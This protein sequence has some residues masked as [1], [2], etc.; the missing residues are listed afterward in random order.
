M[1]R[2]NIGAEILKS[3]E[4]REV[5]IITNDGRS[6]ETISDVIIYTKDRTGEVHKFFLQLLFEEDKEL[7]LVWPA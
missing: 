4:N 2:K 3:L 7:K 6:R 1:V 5:E